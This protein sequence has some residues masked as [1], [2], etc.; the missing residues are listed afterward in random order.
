MCGGVAGRA[1]GATKADV[2][3]VARRVMKVVS[4]Y[5]LLL[6]EDT[7]RLLSIQNIIY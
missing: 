6:L 4:L 3:V 1:A 7:E 2:E 5:M